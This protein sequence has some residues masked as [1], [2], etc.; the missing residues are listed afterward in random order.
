MSTERAVSSV[1]HDPYRELMR[2]TDSIVD[3]CAVACAGISEERLRE[4]AE[5]ADRKSDGK[6][7]LAHMIRDYI[8]TWCP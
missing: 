5:E 7:W 6:S 3:G 1:P 4:I 2:D 8:E